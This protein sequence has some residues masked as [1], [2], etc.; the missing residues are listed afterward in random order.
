M[1]AKPLWKRRRFAVH[2][3]VLGT[4][5]LHGRW[6][7]LARALGSYR[8]QCREQGLPQHL[9][10]LRATDDHGQTFRPLSQAELMRFAKNRGHVQRN[11]CK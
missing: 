5:R 9:I 1:M 2:H 11:L 10:L 6:A 7:P 4:S 8:R 3:P